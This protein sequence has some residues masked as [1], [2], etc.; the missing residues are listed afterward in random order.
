MSNLVKVFK[1][2]ARDLLVYFLAGF[3][4]IL[5]LI[6]LDYNFNELSFFKYTQTIS[7]W[8]VGFIVIAY[9]I[10]NIIFSFMYLFI[11]CT[12][13]EKYLKQTFFDKN[14]EVKC[15]NE[16]PVFKEENELHE[17]FVERHTQLYLMRWN[18]AGAF[19]LVG[20]IHFFI[21]VINIYTLELLVSAIL[22]LS[23]IFLYILS[24]RTEKD[25][26]E[27]ITKIIKYQNK[28]QN[29]NAI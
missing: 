22:I 1:H 4:V 12:G 29:E 14:F 24:L 17:Q 8:V 28:K 13:I 15:K 9:I 18:L 20:I 10:G 7:Y 16:I 25:C 27:R 3:V 19:V 23:G 11:E 21:S 2:L 5:Y 26:T 6:Y